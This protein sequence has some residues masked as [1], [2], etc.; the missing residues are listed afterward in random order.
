[1]THDGRRVLLYPAFID[2]LQTYDNFKYIQNILQN[3][4]DRKRSAEY[5]VIHPDEYEKRLLRFLF[6]KV[7][8]DSKQTLQELFVKSDVFIESTSF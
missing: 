3:I 8:I 6:D 1:M 4:R 7:F 2:C 5:S